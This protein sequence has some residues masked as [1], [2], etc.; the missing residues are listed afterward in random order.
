[1]KNLLTDTDSCNS[2]LQNNKLHPN[3]NK[4]EKTFGLQKI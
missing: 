1:M 4:A 3:N 2:V